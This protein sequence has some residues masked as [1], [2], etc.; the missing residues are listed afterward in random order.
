MLTTTNPTTDPLRP[1]T[2]ARKNQH[3]L[4]WRN[5]DRVRLIVEK[6]LFPAPHAGHDYYIRLVDSAAQLH[7]F[8]NSVPTPL[9]RGA[10][11]E[12]GR[13]CLPSHRLGLP[14]MIVQDAAL[15]EARPPGAE[16]GMP[17]RN[18]ILGL[19]SLTTSL[20]TFATFMTRVIE[21]PSVSFTSGGGIPFQR[22]ERRYCVYQ[23]DNVP[24]GNRHR[25][26]SGRA[27]PFLPQLP[28]EATGTGP[29]RLR[30]A[31]SYW[32]GSRT[33]PFELLGPGRVPVHS[34]LSHLCRRL[35][36]GRTR[37]LPVRQRP[38]VRGI[39]GSCS[40][41]GTRRASPP[42]TRSLKHLPRHCPPKLGPL[43][44]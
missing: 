44:A 32:N 14:S 39:T 26:L 31:S 4:H 42:P 12:L 5:G 40:M 28:R 24:G 7:L 30:R 18:E 6:G 29:E 13:I 1:A 16:I 10:T 25:H 22:S 21:A 36:V 35:P 33:A 34:R 23:S 43:A 37:V 20:K 3:Q 19:I 8:F 2:W 38:S 15:Y 11:G 9:L 17:P 27:Q 41:W